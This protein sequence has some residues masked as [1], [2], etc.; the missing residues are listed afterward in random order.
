MRLDSTDMGHDYSPNI[1]SL[2]IMLDGSLLHT[3]LSLRSIPR[4]NDPKDNPDETPT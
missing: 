1:S 2:P 3:P 4:Q